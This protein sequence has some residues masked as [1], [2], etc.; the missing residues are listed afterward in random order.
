MSPA[1]RILLRSSTT[2]NTG[3]DMGIL[4]GRALAMD[5]HKVV[6]A[7]DLMKSSTM[8]KEALVAG[9]LSAGVDVIDIGV[10]SGPVIGMAAS[11]GD[12]AVLV[13]EYRRSNMI[14]GYLL[15]NS[16]GSLFRK[17]QIRHLNRIFIEPLTL[18][19]ADKLGHV[20]RYTTATE[21]YNSRV[22]KMIVHSP[23]CSVILNCDCG[24]TSESAPMLLNMVGA[25]IMTL[26]AQRDRD[27]STD[28]SGDELT[29]NTDVKEIV[30][31]NAGCIGITMNRIGT[32][33]SVVDEKGE[34]LT[35]DQI[36]AI[37]IMKANPSSIA[38]P[39]DTS[40]VIL[41]A[42]NGLP[43][44]Q[45]RKIVTTDM[46]AGDVCSAVSE[47]A[48]IGYYEGGIIFGGTSM[49][50]DGIRSATAIATIAGNESL[51]TLAGNLTVC[52]NDTK[53]IDCDC[54]PDSF[55]RAMD[56]S[57]EDISGTLSSVDCSW[58]IDMESGWFLISLIKGESPTVVIRAESRDRVY[59]LGLMEIASDLV[60]DCIRGP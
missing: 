14:S 44:D 49:M 31:S 56:S 58:R 59:L 60:D 27:Y 53:E 18:P 4:L 34:V 26:N 23:G 24:P 50:P 6:V 16:D 9:L 22:K 39:I 38:V 28:D 32:M 1:D 12:C 45:E 20:T 41:D 19:G 55:I 15:I 43:K 37:I 40:L 5:Y 29:D 36:F 54:S 33:I 30:K 17:E 10:A 8:M 13:T 21:E 46:S 11:K 3:P 48:S 47:G 7:T 25:D 51:N 2:E 35:D 57:V 52:Y 42:F